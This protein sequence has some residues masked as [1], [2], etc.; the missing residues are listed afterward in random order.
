MDR[1]RSPGSRLPSTRVLA[2]ALVMG[3]N[4]V[5]R[6]YEQLLVEGNLEGRIGDGSYVSKAVSSG[7]SG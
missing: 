6:A 1:S 5:V 4:T 3:R 7:H 2:Q